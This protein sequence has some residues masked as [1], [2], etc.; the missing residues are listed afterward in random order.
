M[1]PIRI[2]LL[3]LA[4]SLLR[5]VSGCTQ[6]PSKTIPFE[7]DTH[8]QSDA[9]PQKVNITVNPLDYAGTRIGCNVRNVELPRAYESDYRFACRFP[10]IDQVSNRPLYMKQWAED[11]AA[12]L[13]KRR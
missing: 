1:K 8:F 7:F 4:L 3:L 6:K 12:E 9:N 13:T 10:I 11:N 5:I 2:V